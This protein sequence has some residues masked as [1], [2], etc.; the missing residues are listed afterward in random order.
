LHEHSFTANSRKEKGE[1][2]NEIRKISILIAIMLLVSTIALFIPKVAA[3]GTVIATSPDPV[4]KTESDVDHNFDLSINVTDV[5]NLYGFELEITWNNTL[6]NYVSFDNSSLNTI[7]P[8]SNGWFLANQ[9]N[10]VTSGVGF[11]DLAA[12]SLSASYTG[13]YEL[14]KVKFLVKGPFCNSVKETAIHFAI[15]KLSDSTPAAID[16]TVNDGLYRIKGNTPTIGLDPTTKKCTQRKESFDVTVG[17]SGAENVVGFDFDIR[18]NTTLIYCKDATFGGVWTGTSTVDQP[19]GKITG[20]ASGTEQSGA[21]TLVTIHFN[22]SATF[23][24]IWKN[25]TIVGWVNNITNSTAIYVQTANLMYTGA[26]TLSYVKGGSSNGIIV[27]P[28]H[29]SYTFAPMKGDINN[30]GKVNIFDLTTICHCYG[31]KDTFHWDIGQQYDLVKIGAQDIIDI[32]DT[33]VITS[34]YTG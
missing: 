27:S 24:H 23:K 17:I 34:S 22:S 15:H 33:I 14:Y 1:M 29:V 2:K 19:N 26:P 12:T 30:D 11:F 31:Y 20:S 21:L 16:H 28:D 7:W 32:Y 25:S 3:D 8:G 13:S 5:T 10:G 4:V 18:F 9:T 6:I